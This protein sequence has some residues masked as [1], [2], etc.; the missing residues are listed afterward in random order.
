M[1][2]IIKKLNPT[3]RPRSP[4]QS[5]TNE[6]SGYDQISSLTV[7][8]GLENDKYIF[9]SLMALSFMISGSSTICKTVVM[10]NN[11]DNNLSLYL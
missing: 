2:T 9:V 7:T 6:A 11:I 8:L 1:S 3:N 4:P 5:A 10:R